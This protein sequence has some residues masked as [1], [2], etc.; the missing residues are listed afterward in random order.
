M[1]FGLVGAPFNKEAIAQAAKEAQHEHGV[2][3]PDATTVVVQRYVQA[4]V[5]TVFNAAAAGAIK[6]QPSL[7][8]EFL[9]WSAGQQGDGLGLAVGGLTANS[10]HLCGRRKTDRLRGGWGGAEEADFIS[11]AVAF[12]RAGTRAG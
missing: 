3:I 12:L 6:P 4:L 10:S 2:G 5:Q 9:G 1:G 8:V 7:G 11:A